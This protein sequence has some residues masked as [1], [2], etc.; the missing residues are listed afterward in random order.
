ML[1]ICV[2]PGALLTYIYA[3][4]RIIYMYTRC[5]C[6]GEF[7]YPLGGKWRP[8]I[9]LIGLTNF[10]QKFNQSF[11]TS[12]YKPSQRSSYMSIYQGA[13]IRTLESLSDVSDELSTIT[14][15]SSYDTISSLY[16]STAISTSVF[17]RLSIKICSHQERK[18]R[19][20]LSNTTTYLLQALNSTLN[21]TSLNLF[22]STLL[23]KR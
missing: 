14:G 2:R 13:V 18:P 21:S 4:R 1:W 20:R 12:P 15:L 17:T 11:S 16:C 22:C 6:L 5:A 3:S 9:P 23:H 19:R 10:C 7:G 8:G